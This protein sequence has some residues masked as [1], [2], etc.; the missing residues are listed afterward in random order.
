MTI[1]KNVA[2]DFIEQTQEPRIDKAAF[3]HQQGVVIGNVILGADVFV[4]P[5]ASVRGDEGGPIHIGEKSNVQDHVVIHGLETFSAG[6]KVE[7]NIRTV[8]DK[9]YSVYIGTEVSLAHQCQIHGPAVVMDGSFVGMQT[10][11]FRSTVGRNCVVEPAAKLIGVEVQDNRYV[12][13]GLV[14]TTQEQ[15]DALPEIAEGYPYAGLNKAVVHVNVQ[16]CRGYR[17]SFSTFSG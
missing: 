4:A 10:L 16:L 6:S 11:I 2:A 17:K 5:F 14:V 8:A 3:V 9:E 13:A 15:A 7:A 1:H 12:P